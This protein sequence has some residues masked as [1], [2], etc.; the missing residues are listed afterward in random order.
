MSSGS[1][2]RLHIDRR[3]FLRIAGT[4]IGAAVLAACG[5]SA[6]SA[7]APAGGGAAAG[8]A[9]STF[10]AAA[11][12]RPASADTKTIKF[13]AK[14]GPYVIALSNSYIGNVWRTQMIKMAKAFAELP[15]IKPS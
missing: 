2:D 4:G 12:Y 15:E 9:A 8:G 10:D 11:C 14:T 6:P 1:P 7:S 3:R 13:D 5:A